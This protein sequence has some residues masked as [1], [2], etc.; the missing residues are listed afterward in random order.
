MKANTGSFSSLG[1]H[2]ALY[3]RMT[4]KEL[5]R[6]KVVM[7]T[8]LLSIS[9]LALFYYGVGLESK[10]S[11]PNQS[12]IEIFGRGQVFLYLGTFFIQ[13][14][15]VFLVLFSSM[16]AI[17]AEVENGQMLA[18]L[19]R[20]IPRWHVFL[21]KWAGYAIWSGLYAG[22]LF[23]AVVGIVY[24][25]IGMFPG[26]EPALKCLFLFISIPVVLSAVSLLGSSYLP[27]LANGGASALLFGMGMLGGLLE[28]FITLTQPQAGFEKF[29]LLI[30]MLIPTDSLMKRVNYELIGGNDIPS[31]LQ[32]SMGPIS[33][34][35]APSNA[36][37]IYTAV[38]VILLL[39]WGCR[40]F[41]KR[42]I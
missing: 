27:T 26:I 24:A 32:M 12:A 19:S 40:H 38:Y 13:F 3:I 30:S 25:Q 5:T 17:A 37:L 41:M 2:L 29:G 16:G 42:D 28:K 21:G 20:P 31:T 1:S 36:F 8:L 10:F 4:A 39:L 11:S 34:A 14:I 35:D 15:V 22:I 23:A 9:F 33:A 7:I 18:V 6:K